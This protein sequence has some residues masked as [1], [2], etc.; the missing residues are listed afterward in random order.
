MEDSVYLEHLRL[1]RPEPRKVFKRGY[2]G[3]LAAHLLARLVNG[4]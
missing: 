3:E 4:S 2:I 1:G